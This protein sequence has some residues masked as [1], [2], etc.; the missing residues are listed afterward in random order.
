MAWV[1]SDE[2]QSI[3]P[4]ALK[5]ALSFNQA[6]RAAE[7]DMIDPDFLIDIMQQEDM[8]HEEGGADDV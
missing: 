8:L 5:Q 1:D 4:A 2:M 6:R 3:D 7:A